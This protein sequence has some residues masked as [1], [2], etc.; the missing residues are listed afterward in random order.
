MIRRGAVVL[1]VA[2]VIACVAAVPAS[3]ARVGSPNIK[4][5]GHNIIQY[6]VKVC[7]ARS[8]HIKLRFLAGPSDEETSATI[9]TFQRPSCQTY[10]EK[11]PNLWR[12]PHSLPTKVD[13]TAI[14]TVNGHTERS[15]T[16]GE[17]DY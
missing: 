4:F 3:A 12:H 16:I 13:V 6:S 9:R 8:T 5:V 1:V 11:E 17:Y 10:V 15:D 7:G 14:L 2:A